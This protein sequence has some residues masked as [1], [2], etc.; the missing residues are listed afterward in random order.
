MRRRGRER[1]VERRDH[2]GLGHRDAEPLHDAAE[3]VAVLGKIDGLRRRADDGNARRLEL[4]G[5][6]ER[7][8]AAELHDD[9]LGALLLVDREHVF[10]GERL[11]VEL[12]G[13]VEV[14]RDR[15]RVAVHHD[16]LEAR[17]AQG[18]GRVHAA[19][20]E[21]DALSDAVGPAAEHHDLAPVAHRHLV[22]AVVRRVVVRLVL[23]A[24]HRNRAVAVHEAELA[25]ALADPA[26]RDAEDLGEVR[27]GEPVVL[28]AHEQ[29][30]GRLGALVSE[31]LLLE[32]DELAHLLE[33][34]LLD[35]RARVQRLHAH[36][37]AKRLVDDE[38]PLARRLGEQVEQL[39]GSDLSWKSRA[40]PRPPARSRASAPPFAASPCR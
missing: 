23:N 35:V 3:P 19:V 24:A 21:L 26:L 4:V 5:D 8:L 36:A 32:L 34:P 29:L 16:R 39:L 12:V 14:G 33:E 37:L 13:G 27:V 10:D 38:L 25:A 18:E 31:Q 11:E 20:V 17:V 30:V 9:A 1:V 15:L 40:K 6:V 7:R 22:G 2:V 28:R